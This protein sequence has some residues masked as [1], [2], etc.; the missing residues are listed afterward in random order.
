MEREVCDTP[1]KKS[2]M[3]STPVRS[4]SS[5]QTPVRDNQTKRRHPALN[6][7]GD[8]AMLPTHI[9]PPSGLTKFI[10]RNPFDADLTSRL[11]LSVISP[12]FFSKVF[13]NI[14][15]KQTTLALE[16]YASLH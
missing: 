3:F 4:P 6:I 2:T 7:F 10:A 11:H 16:F 14:L 13:I 12:T 1:K 15:K 8:L 5:H 9:T